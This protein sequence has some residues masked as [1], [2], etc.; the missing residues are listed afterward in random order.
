MFTPWGAPIL[1]DRLEKGLTYVRTKRHG[2]FMI[3][4]YFAENRL[5]VAARK[6]AA[7]FGQYF[8]YEMDHAWTVPLWELPQLWQR[9]AETHRPEM[10]TD[11]RAHLISILSVHHADY[12]AEA[13]GA[14]DSPLDD[15]DSG[16]AT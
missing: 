12:L 14:D 2:G 5:S 11:P 4:R 10:E 8:A 7:R 1:N 15:D 3:A 16:P 9:F 6:K 13:M